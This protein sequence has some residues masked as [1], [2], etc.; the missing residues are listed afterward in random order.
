MIRVCD[1]YQLVLPVREAGQP[2]HVDGV[3][4][5]AE[6]GATL[7]NAA[8]DFRADALVDT[9]L[10]ALMF[11]D[12]G[13]DVV[14]QELRYCRHGSENTDVA[15]YS[16][17]ELAEFGVHPFHGLQEFTSITPERLTGR[18]NGDAAPASV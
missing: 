18:C 10:H 6:I 16:L 12:E 4:A 8:H 2:P 13:A 7:F 15:L 3:P 17:G 1:H 14:G 5:D 11:L 9:D